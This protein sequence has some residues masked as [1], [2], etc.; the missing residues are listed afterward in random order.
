MLAD[1][2]Q[3]ESAFKQELI[4]MREQSYTAIDRN[5]I[6]NSKAYCFS[7]LKEIK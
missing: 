6:E 1:T 7:N 4:L 2:I 5:T 3:S